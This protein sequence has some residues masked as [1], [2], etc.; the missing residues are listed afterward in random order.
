[1]VNAV[2]WENCHRRKLTFLILPTDGTMGSESPVLLV[3]REREGDGIT[4]PCC[5]QTLPPG[6]VHGG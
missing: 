2:G 5:E 3:H 6:P 1:M 4:W